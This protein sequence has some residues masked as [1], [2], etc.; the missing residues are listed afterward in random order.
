MATFT[1]ADVLQARSAA[2]IFN[3]WLAY[4][5]NPPPGL[6][7]VKT[8]NWRTGG[9]Y[10][11]LIRRDS[12]ELEMLYKLIA[13][14]GGS[15]FIRYATGLWLKWLGEDFFGEPKQAAVFAT[16]N[17]TLTVA[18]GFGPYGP[19]TMKVRATN[20][21]TYS[22]V[23]PVTIP[24]GG[25]TGP[26]AF[27]ADKAGAA[28]NVGAHEIN[29]LLSPNVLGVTVDN[30][31][32][33][34]TGFDEE[35]DDR[36]KVRLLAKW[37]I[38]SGAVAPGSSF[39]M[40]KD[41]YIY[42]ALTASPEVQKVAVLASLNAN[43]GMYA[44]NTESVIVAGNGVPVSG[45]GVSAVQAYLA[46]RIG[47]DETLIVK[48]ASVVTE[49][50]AGTVKIRSAYAA[51]GLAPIATSLADLDKRIPIGGGP[52]GVPQSEFIAAIFYDKNAIYDAQLT[53]PTLSGVALNYDQILVT[54]PSAL[55]LQT[56]P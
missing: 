1:L 34:T 2:Q 43:T 55:V 38:L 13:A 29:A 8:S 22:S 5:A 47:L 17:V 28:A 19:L 56:V 15:A 3:D 44:S 45:G 51:S 10:L 4:M 37:G 21:Q 16:T 7:K 39:A 23:A 46:P 27:I 33:V 54:D 18:P 53:A 31:A 14:L 52:A 36:Y 20:G 9:A 50:L 49:A 6:D 35:S 42:G 30:A 26:V 24:Q 41:G 25:T 48:S 12:I 11:T 32:A 40:V